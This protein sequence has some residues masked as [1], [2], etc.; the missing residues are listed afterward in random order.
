[1]DWGRFAR[2]L[3]A[4]RMEAV[5]LRRKAYL[6]DEIKELTREEWKQL[7]WHESLINGDGTDRPAD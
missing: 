3:E 7:D 4:E 1:M 6:R 2:V 5:E